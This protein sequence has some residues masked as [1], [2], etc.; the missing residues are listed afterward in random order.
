V[1]VARVLEEVTGLLRA[2]AE[3]KG[4]TLKTEFSGQPEML[5][6]EE[7]LRQLWTNLISNSI[8]YTPRGGRVVASVDQKDGR[9]VGVVSDTG[10]GIA[11]DDLPRIFDEFYRTKQA[12]SIEEHGTGLGLSIVKQIV[13][14]YG[15]TI[16]VESQLGKGT[17]VTF[18]LPRVAEAGEEALEGG[19]VVGNRNEG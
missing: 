17:T 4:L 14:S 1:S 2:E 9:V 13:E 11:A 10:V 7:H 3:R 19:R 15:G 16:D 12:K 5:A 6:D 8:K 18:T